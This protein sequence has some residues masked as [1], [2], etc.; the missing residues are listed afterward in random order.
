MTSGYPLLSEE[1]LAISAGVVLPGSSVSFDIVC[2]PNT[3]GRREEERED[4]K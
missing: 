1:V 3:E 2:H 4:P